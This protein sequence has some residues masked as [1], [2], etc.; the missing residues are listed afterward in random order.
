M[1][2][3]FDQVVCSGVIQ[4]CTFKED[5]SNTTFNSML[6][7]CTFNY[8]VNNA[9]LFQ[10]SSLTFKN[11][12]F[13][14]TMTGEIQTPDEIIRSLLASDE[15]TQVN[16]YSEAGVRKLRVMSN[17]SLLIPSGVILMWSGTEIPYGW[18]ICD[19]T[20]G[21]PNLVGKFIKA[22]A[23]AD[24]VGDNDS[25]LDE[26]NELI[27]SQD[28]LPKHS[29]PHKAH[30]H[31]LS[32]DLSGTTGSSGD[33]SVSL[34]YSDYNWGIESVS[35]TFVTSVTGEG[36][37]TETGTVDGVSNIK[38]QGGTA[39]G[40]SHTHSISLGTDEGT[41]LSSATSEEQ[42]LSDSELPNK[43]QILETRSYSLVVIKKL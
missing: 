16:V 37:T 19:G 17:S 7:N 8:V 14:T 18:A 13:Q 31:S 1:F 42:T 28:Y 15:T 4:E 40:G 20:N 3:S 11:C 32:G 29:H 30:T 26:N 10:D 2:G 9:S 33:L 6:D 24:E 43:P 36:I 41:S 34:E 23:S 35:K 12:Q 27:L 5:V 21:T 22:V 39:T 25:I 38:T